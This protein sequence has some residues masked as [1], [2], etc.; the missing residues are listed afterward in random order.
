M[1]ALPLH[2]AVVHVPIGLSVM[3]PFLAAGVALAWRRGALP[4]RAW[5][6]VVLFQ[7]AVVTAGGAAL[8]TGEREERRV[9]AVVGRAAIHAHEAR[10]D[11]FVW[12]AAATAAVA[13]ATFVA[14]GRGTTVCQGL[15]VTGALLSLGLVLYA[16]HGGGELVYGRGAATA[17][18]ERATGAPPLPLS[19]ETAGPRR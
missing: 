7:V 3:A 16:G 9:A 12:T 5:W 2:P 8:A 10:A 4:R 14:R 1:S 18:A 17:Y 15:T 6:I 13:A 11:A 19:P